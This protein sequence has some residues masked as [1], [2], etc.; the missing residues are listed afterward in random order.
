LA[1]ALAPALRLPLISKDD[2]KE[3]LTDSLDGPAGDLSWSRRVGAAAWAVLWRLAE[4]C[5]SAVVEANFRP[6]SADEQ[7]RLRRLNATIVEIY[8]RCPAD[9]VARRF[10]E[11]APTAHPAH[12]L[13]E[14]T[15]EMIAEFDRPMAVAEVI[16]VD[17]TKPVALDELA[18]RITGLLATGGAPAS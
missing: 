8:C 12:P 15:A 11:R 16:E 1:T 18:G 10:A 5:P 13:T 14:L 17:T 7:E 9:E 6:G 4:R 3:A 2:I